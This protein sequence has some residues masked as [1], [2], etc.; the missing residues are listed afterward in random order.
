MK[1]VISACA[2]SLL[3]MTA[4]AGA[5]NTGSK[6]WT[7]ARDAD[8]VTT[9]GVTVRQLDDADLIG[10][11]GRDLGD[12]EYVLLSADGE[13]SAVVVELDDDRFGDDRYVKIMLEGLTL[14]EDVDDDP[15]DWDDEVEYDLVSTITVAEARDMKNFR[16]KR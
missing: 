10:E 3:A 16:L 12:V 6:D 14:R 15:D 2:V 11:D 9:L 7:R 8:Q 13:A 4:P 1:Y 5:D